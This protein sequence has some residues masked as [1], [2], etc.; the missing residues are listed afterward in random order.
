MDVL[1]REVPL[2]MYSIHQVPPPDTRPPVENSR[3]PM[4]R[5]RTNTGSKMSQRSSPKAKVMFD[6][7]A[8][9]D[10]EITVLEGDIV[11]IISMN[12][13]QDGW[14][15]IKKGSHEGFVPDN[16]LEKLGTDKRKLILQ[17]HLHVHVHVHECMYMYM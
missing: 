14:W 17:Q 15:L 8:T 10:D 3:V 12:T 13:D 11:D 2:Y 16:F 9:Q 5:T 7:K 6:Y 4:E 1:N